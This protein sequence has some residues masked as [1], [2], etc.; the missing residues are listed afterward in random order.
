MRISDWSSDVCSSDLAIAAAREHGDLSENA[1]YHAAREHQS[2][3]EGRI[4]ELED[5][6]SRSEERRVGKEC[7]ST[8][9]SR[10]SPYQSQ[11]KPDETDKTIKHTYDCRLNEQT[12]Q[13]HYNQENKSAK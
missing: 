3:I 4:G 2:F 12:I 10:W 7:V 8:C 5:Q 11:K 1:E 13:H 6:L 9:R